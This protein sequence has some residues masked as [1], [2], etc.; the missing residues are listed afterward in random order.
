MDENVLTHHIISPQ[1]FMYNQFVFQG[2]KI[3]KKVKIK[4]VFVAVY[5]CHEYILP[6][7]KKEFCCW[8]HHNPV[9]SK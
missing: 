5:S 1:L 2:M 6:K 7:K 8:E 9:V 3:N 4:K